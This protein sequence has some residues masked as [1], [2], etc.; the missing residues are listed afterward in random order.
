MNVLL[1]FPEYQ[2]Q[3]QHLAEALSLP[4]HAINVHH[5]P[6]NE[7]LV[8]L[9]DI[10]V[11]HA[12]IYC[13]LENPNS[14]LIE[15]LLTVKTLQKEN[16]KKFTLV[17]PYL[18]YMRQDMVFHKGEAVSQDI[19]GKYLA[20]LFDDIA[21][22]DAHLHRTESLSQVFPGTNTS[23]I[24]ATLPFSHL[25]QQ[26]QIDALLLG[27]DE[28]SEQWVKQIAT[29]CK[30]DYA[31]A[32][33]VRHSD[34]KVSIMLPDY[35][36]ENK[37][38]VLVDDVISSGG[39][40]INIARQLHEKNIKQLDVIVTHALFDTNTHN[41]LK[42]AGISEIWSS[43]SIPHSTNKISIVPSVA[44]QIKNWIY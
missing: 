36:F 26:M 11:N 23:H 24:S 13:G 29:F 25:L 17:A 42:Q 3:A 20:D 38:I 34:K 22:V 41:K 8:S 28:E 1:Y 12:I 32:R 21:T 16:C 18:C 40:M 39:T 14:K 5:F 2:T 4:A 10:S 43:D 9:P 44:E 27:P 6:D 19:I 33:K 15:L 30:L 31:V 35:D 7:S 37:H